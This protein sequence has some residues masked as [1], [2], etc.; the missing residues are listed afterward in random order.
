M[1]IRIRI[2]AMRTLLA[3]TFL[4]WIVLVSGCSLGTQ[5]KVEAFDPIQVAWGEA[6]QPIALRRITVKL[7]RNESIGAKYSGLACIEEGKLRWRGGR[8]DV[9]N[10]AFSDVFRNELIGAGYNVVG[11]P[12]SLF[13]EEYERRTDLLAGGMIRDMK[14]HIC[15]PYADEGDKDISR[16]HAYLKVKWQFYSRSEKR[17]V[18][19][20]FTE[21]AYNQPGYAP[22]DETDYL[23][24]SF[25]MAVRNLLADAKL[26][27]L[28]MSPPA[29]V[30]EAD[31]DD[32]DSDAA[33]GGGLLQDNFGIEPVKRRKI[34]LEEAEDDEWEDEKEKDGP[35]DD[36][37]WDEDD[38]D[39]DQDREGDA[40]DD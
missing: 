4:G 29:G 39:D 35:G 23:L 19:E 7:P 6:S 10:E 36:D 33:T 16:G 24:D 8:I 30:A 34:D 15:H 9:T 26:H 18:Y 11:D 28:L 1:Y 14:L 38:K 31:D 27:A 20:T 22:A 40:S 21:G 13:K 32:I 25:S 37:E 12:Y 5:K 2:D 3:S 17:I